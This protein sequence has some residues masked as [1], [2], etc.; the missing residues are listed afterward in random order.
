[1]NEQTAAKNI[2]R[3]ISILMR[4]LGLS[5]TQLAR[6]CGVAVTTVIRAKEAGTCRPSSLA[7]IA[8]ALHV[9]VDE[10]TE[11]SI[12]PTEADNRRFLGLNPPPDEKTTPPLPIHIPGIDMQSLETL[13]VSDTAMRPTLEDGDLVWFR[14]VDPNT[15]RSG[16]LVVMANELDY[17]VRRL[18]R[19][20][21]QTYGVAD[22]PD[23]PG[24]Q[25]VEGEVL[26]LAVAKC[27]VLR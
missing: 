13:T 14:K 5:A 7:A 21:K 17:F 15:L 9:S 12:N 26:G 25:M 24:S 19:D 16:D 27:S 22:N 4:E 6:T 11:D 2:S 20:G 10:L 3:N 8:R 1:M 18:E 23:Y